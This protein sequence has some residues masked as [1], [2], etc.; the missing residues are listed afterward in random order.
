VSRTLTFESG[1]FEDVDFGIPSGG[2]LILEGP[3]LKHVSRGRFENRGL[4]DCSAGELHLGTEL[5]NQRILRIGDAR[6]V[7]SSSDGAITNYKSIQVVGH[8]DLTDTILVNRGNISV[9]SSAILRLVRTRLVFPESTLSGSGTIIVES[10][11]PQP[12][13]FGQRLVVPAGL[14]LLVDGGALE[15]LHTSVSKVVILGVFDWRRGALRKLTLEITKTGKGSLE[16]DKD[17]YLTTAVLVNRGSLSLS[18]NTVGG[19]LVNHGHFKVTG[20]ATVGVWGEGEQL[21]NNGVLEVDI[22]APLGAL[23]VQGVYRQS[24]EATLR[25][26]C[27]TSIAPRPGPV[28]RATRIEV[29]KGLGYLELT[30]T[31]APIDA[32]RLKPL[33]FTS[34]RGRFSCTLSRGV[35]WLPTHEPG[36]LSFEAMVSRPRLPLIRIEP[37]TSWPRDHKSM[38]SAHNRIGGLVAQLAGDHSLEPAVAIAVFAVESA[39]DHILGRLTIRFEVHK[40][41]AAW[42]IANESVF[43]EHFDFDRTLKKGSGLQNPKFEQPHLG[44]RYSIKPGGRKVPVHD[45]WPESEDAALKLARQLT[46]DDELCLRCISMGSPQIMGSEHLVIGKPSAVV[47]YSAFQADEEA[48]VKGFFEFCANAKKPSRGDLLVYARQHNWAQFAYYYNGPKNVTVY[49]PRLKA[50]Y[51][52]VKALGL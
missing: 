33:S 41:Y 21:V 50:A 29:E 32:V 8:A 12:V 43:D 24:G 27:G 52:R 47:M 28:M 4:I 25:L 26:N 49:E 22:Q 36:A 9:S 44:H 20:P 11:T 3:G 37:E 14:T 51:E 13:S 16:S 31:D 45:G 5:L 7:T 1:T 2:S 48:H 10:G 40:L 38:A 35:S 46:N 34:F 15:G 19:Q 39:T 23:D 42:G 17:R 30:T 6:I 18:G